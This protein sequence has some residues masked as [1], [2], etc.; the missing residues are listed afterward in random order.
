MEF[1]VHIEIGRI[2]G[3]P[4]AQQDLLQQEAACARELAAQGLIRSLWRVPGRR[5]N[6]GIWVSDDCDKLHAA[7][8]SLPLFPFLTVTVHP[9]ARH[10]NAPQYSLSTDPRS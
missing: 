10:P 6:W 3:D 5:A 1:L 8:S 7:I 4:G 2:E 9:L